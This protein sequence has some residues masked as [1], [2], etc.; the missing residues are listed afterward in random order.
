MPNH[1]PKDMFL[2]W[3][4]TIGVPVWGRIGREETG[5]FPTGASGRVFE[6]GIGLN[7]SSVP[8]GSYVQEMAA[9]GGDIRCTYCGPKVTTYLVEKFLRVTTAGYPDTA[10]PTF[11]VQGGI[12]VANG[13]VQQLGAVCSTWELSCGAPGD[14][15]QMALAW[16][17]T[18]NAPQ[19]GTT[20]PVTS[21]LS[22]WWRST[23]GGKITLAI[24]GGA[25]GAYKC[26]AITAKGNNNP[27]PDSSLDDY[28]DSGVGD[29]LWIPGGY[30]G[31]E[32]IIGGSV[33]LGY[34][35]SYDA[36]MGSAWNYYTVVWEFTDGTT[37]HRLTLGPFY[38]DEEGTQFQVEGRYIQGI[39]FEAPPNRKA[40][41]FTPA[42]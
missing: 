33:G 42:I 24:D 18:N 32:E 19:S 14:P 26:Q 15:V 10:L 31:G 28:D 35:L 36:F 16:L 17:T 29:E 2:E 40:C 21:G 23:K 37:T 13:W 7:A 27:Y 5:K 30:L 3:C 6:R 9:P 38:R 11:G 12:N 41:T 20:T 34:A 25:A 39:E 4:P 22:S 1:F 8:E